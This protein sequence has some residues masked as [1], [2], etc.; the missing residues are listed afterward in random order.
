MQGDMAPPPIVF[1]IT[2]AAAWEEARRAGVYEHASLATE[3]FIHFSDLEQVVRVADR[4]FRGTPDLVLLCVAAERL[5]AP[6]RYEHVEEAGERFPHLYGP[7]NLDAVVEAVAFV[8]GPDGF[9]LPSRA[10][11]LREEE[12]ASV[13]IG[14][15]DRLDGP[16]TLVESDP[17]WPELY[18]REAARIRGA[19]GDRVLR[20]EHVGSTSVPGLIAKPIVDIALVVPDPADEPGYASALEAAGYRLRIRT[21]EW[22]EHRMFKGPDTDVNLHVFGPGSAEVESMVRFRDRLRADEGAR[23][24]YAAEKRALA[25][26]RWA[27][28][29]YYADAKG[30]VVEEILAR[31]R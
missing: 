3:G 6:L 14:P 31:P 8:E 22:E 20:I 21:P 11:A 30:P 24:R 7:L 16:V 26:R 2:T 19:L 13:T 17:R 15:V 23:E 12:L 4:A 18:E 25:G 28:V 10:A 27:H 5:E 9:A 1:H 29:Q